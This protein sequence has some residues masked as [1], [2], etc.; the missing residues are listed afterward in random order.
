MLKID[1]AITYATDRGCKVSD[2]FKRKASGQKAF[3]VTANDG[4]NIMI[5]QASKGARLYSVGGE[6]ELH[7]H[8]Q[9]IIIAVNYLTK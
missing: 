4:C 7:N 1:D 9:A 5:T 8:A 2:I 3:Y 6:I